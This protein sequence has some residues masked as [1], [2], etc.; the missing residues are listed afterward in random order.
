[1]RLT[2]VGLIREVYFLQLVKQGHYIQKRFFVGEVCEQLDDY[3]K[4]Q[5]C[6]GLHLIIYY[7]ENVKQLSWK[8]SFFSL[9]SY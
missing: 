8:V 1:M 2:W 9:E 7:M 6:S 3:L 4:F 5:A